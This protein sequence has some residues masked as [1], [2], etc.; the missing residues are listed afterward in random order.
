MFLWGVVQIT[1]AALC[2][3]APSVP[4]LNSFAA[5]LSCLTC[6]SSSR[7]VLFENSGAWCFPLED[8][9]CRKA[10]SYAR[11]QHSA[12]TLIVSG[13]SSSGQTA[14]ETSACHSGLAASHF[15]PEQRRVWY[16]NAGSSVVGRWR[17]VLRYFPIT[18]L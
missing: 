8:P 7:V 12:I 13:S 15:G 11:D 10:A 17:N 16:F 3:L 14:F 5:A 18:A 6:R 1:A 9:T 4:S 2:T